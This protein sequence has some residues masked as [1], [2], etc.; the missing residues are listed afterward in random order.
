[1]STYTYPLSGWVK[2]YL[3]LYHKAIIVRVH[4][5]GGSTQTPQT[6]ATNA[7]HCSA[8]LKY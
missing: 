8:V 6:P 3:Y 7:A 1:M 2:H 5:F 4:T